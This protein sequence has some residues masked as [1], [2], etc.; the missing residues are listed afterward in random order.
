MEHTHRSVTGRLIEGTQP[1]Y[2]PYPVIISQGFPHVYPIHIPAD[3]DVKRS[4][5]TGIFSSL[6]RLRLPGQRGAL[7]PGEALLTV[8]HAA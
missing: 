4:E 1:Q 5:F 6:A 3:Q 8:S 2:A 7:A